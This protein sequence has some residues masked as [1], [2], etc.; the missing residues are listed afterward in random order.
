MNSNANSKEV[1][2]TLLDISGEELPDFLASVN[3]VGVPTVNA[4]NDLV[5]PHLTT[6]WPAS[7]AMLDDGMPVLALPTL[8]TLCF[9]MGATVLGHPVADGNRDGQIGAPAAAVSQI[10]RPFRDAILGA[11]DFH[12]G[13]GMWGF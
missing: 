9:L 8:D 13:D 7:K 1:A 4:T 12:E 6:R 5:E 2:P 3:I 11:M 10:A